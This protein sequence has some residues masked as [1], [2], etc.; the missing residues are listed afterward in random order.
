MPGYGQSTVAMNEPFSRSFNMKVFLFLIAGLCTALCSFGQFSIKG[1]IADQHQKLPFGTVRFLALDSTMVQGVVTDSL[2]TF[3]IKNVKP[4]EYFIAVSMIGYASFWQRIVVDDRSIFLEDIILK[5]VTT[6]LD[7]VVVRE[8]KQL[9]DQ[10]I[11]RLVINLDNS[12]TS[13]GNTILE[14]LQKS[15]GIV[16][17]KQNNSIAMNGRSGVRLMINNK[18][19]QLSPD[20]VIQMLDG[21]SATNVEKI[22]LI[23]APP[24]SYDAGGSAGV[25]HIVTKKNEDLGTNGSFGLMAGAR[26]AETFGGNFNINHRNKNFAYFLDYAILRNHNLHRMKLERRSFQVVD[27]AVS[28][29]SSREN[30]TTQ[31]NLSAGLEWKF[32]ERM[33]LNLL[34][35]GYRRDWGLSAITTENNHIKIDSTDRTT[36]KVQE[37]NI[38]QSVTGNVG[39]QARTNSKSDISFNFDYLYYHNDNPSTYDNTVFHRQQG[40]NTFSKIDVSKT[41]PIQILI[42]KVDYRYQVSPSFAWEAGIKA[43]TSTLDNNVLVQRLLHDAWITDSIFTSYSNLNE[44]VYA[45]YVATRWQTGR[46]WQINGGLR[47]EYTQTTISSPTQKD[48]VKRKYGYLFPNVSIKKNLDTEKDFYFSYSRRITRPTYNDI[49]P[50]VFFWGVNSFSAGNTSLYPSVIDVLTGGY[51]VKQWI[52]SMQFS[53][54]R[55]EIVTLQPEIDSASGSLTFRSQNLRYLNTFGIT[56]SYTLRVAHWWEV[57]STLTPQYQVVCTSHLMK[58]KTWNMSGLNLH[59]VNQIKLAR[60]FSIEISGMYQSKSSSGISEFLAFG[61]LNAGIQKKFKNKGTIKLSMDD[62]LYTNNWRIKTNSSENRLHAYFDYDWHNQFIR[63]TYTRNIG[64]TKL[65]TLKFKSGSEEE[66]ERISN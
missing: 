58:N 60:E 31:H 3:V 34:F 1:R 56:G 20:A 6:E 47:Y 41:T 21:M 64:N 44:Q 14:V 63:L 35:T 62:I 43:V 13:S 40:I 22:E 66:R 37:S 8:E 30:I 17:N 25:I 49:A 32:S 11:D 46:Q 12:I 50:Y 16:V 52:V 24:S 33:T 28:N 51:H 15:P 4:G 27:Q 29:Y 2:G 61:S 53:R 55:N 10:Q 26:W 59:V 57:Q 23:T 48:L 36:M 5:E 38:W 39:L 65:R 54:A 19:M 7:E 45:A 42:G 9:I 18:E